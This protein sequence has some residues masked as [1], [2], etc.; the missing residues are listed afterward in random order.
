MLMVIE[1]VLDK[2]TV[3]AFREKLD[4]APWSD[5]QAT[6]G[7]LAVQV[8][9]NQQLPD[10]CET[11]V[12]LGNQILGEL[13]KNP[14]F[15]SAALP[16]HI[17]PPKFNRYSGGGHYGT[18][19]DS[20][21]MPLPESR[22][23]LRTDLSATLFLSGPEEYDGGE[24]IIETRFGAQQVKLPAGDMVLYP[25]SSLHQVTPVT[26]GARTCSFFW[27]QSMVRDDGERELLFDLDQAI[28]C[29]SGSGDVKNDAAVLPLSGIYH[30]LLRRWANV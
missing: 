20:A 28:Q 8:K 21:I 29:L 6:A 10:F 19:V 11:A 4:R 30:N 16:N 13:G 14:R 23:L 26:R 15:I 7:S 22:Q 2:A 18:H 27:M 1:G 5:G 17:Y 9:S 3:L 24:L 12:A 25:A